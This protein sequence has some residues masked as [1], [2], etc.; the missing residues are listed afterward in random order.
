MLFEAFATLLEYPTALLADACAVA[1]EEAA[2][3]YPTAAV[4]LAAFAAAI[5]QMSEV[6]LQEQYART[7]DFDADTALYVGHHLFGEEGRRGLLI[8]GL[9][10]RHR[11][12]GLDV[13][14]ELADHVSPVLRSLA[15]DGDSEEAHELAWMALRPSIAKMLSAVE[16]RAVPYAAVLRA[17]AGILDEQRGERFEP[18]KDGCRLSSSPYFLT[19]LS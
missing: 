6:E 3:R 17:L 2:G 18:E 14:I 8:A 12:L 15:L 16:R 19:L 11:R 5:A 10:E 1:I 7:F 13:G 9:V 4:E